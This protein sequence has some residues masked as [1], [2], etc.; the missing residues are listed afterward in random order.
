MSSLVTDQVV[1]SGASFRVSRS[2][3]RYGYLKD[4]PIEQRMRDLRVHSILEV[5]R[6]LGGYGWRGCL[7]QSTLYLL[8]RWARE[9]LGEEGARRREVGVAFRVVASKLRKGHAPSQLYP[10]TA[11][12]LRLLSR[13]A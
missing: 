3:R 2:A 7:L 4:Y 8:S 13:A 9:L 11:M 6:R 5:G 10:G 1:L 12:A